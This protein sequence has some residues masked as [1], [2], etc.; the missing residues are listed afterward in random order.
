MSSESSK[1][2]NYPLGHSKAITVK[3]DPTLTYPRNLLGKRVVCTSKKP[4]IPFYYNYPRGHNLTTIKNGDE[5]FIV[6]VHKCPHGMGWD[7][8][9]E[10]EKAN[11]LPNPP[12]NN[13][14]NN[15]FLRVVANLQDP[16]KSGVTHRFK[17]IFEL[18][19]PTLIRLRKWKPPFNSIEV[20]FLNLDRGQNKLGNPLCR[21]FSLAESH[22]E[23]VINHPDFTPIKKQDEERVLDTLKCLTTYPYNYHLRLEAQTLKH[24]QKQGF[25]IEILTKITNPTQVVNV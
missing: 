3:D 5:G 20:L 22:G 16:T 2:Q 25:D 15:T 8:H 6:S 24:L 14:P 23:C 17:D 10:V 1:Y 12:L 9:V 4:L 11:T 21:S 18:S 7:V 13:L 19:K